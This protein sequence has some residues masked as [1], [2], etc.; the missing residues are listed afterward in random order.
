MTL[1]TPVRACKDC[2]AWL[3]ALLPL[4]LAAGLSIPLLGDNAFVG[5]EPKTLIAAGILASGPQ[6]LAE[7]VD[8]VADKSSE[9]ALG[10]PLLVFVWG[11]IAGWSEPAIRTLPVLAGLLAIAVV[12]RAGRDLFTSQAGLY[13]ALLLSGSAFFLIFMTHA[14]SFST[15]A[16]CAALCAWC[17]WRIALR[18]QP[19]GRMAQPGLLLGATG[20]L[21]MHYFGSLLLPALCVFHLLFVP[22]NPR[23]WR[24][25]ILIGLAGLAATAQLPVFLVGFR[26]TVADVVLHTRALTPPALL[27][28]FVRYLFNGLVVL[29]SF[30]AELLAILLPL[31]LVMATWWRLR[32][33][34]PTSTVWFLGFVA[35][36]F[37]LLVIGANEILRVVTESRMRYLIAMWPPLALLAGAGLCRL[38]RSQRL[39]VHGLLALWLFAGA[40]LG[41]ATD[42]RYQPGFTDRS[43]EHLVYRFVAERIPRTDAL[44]LDHEAERIYTFRL[45]MPF[46][47]YNR[48]RDDPLKHVLRLHAVHPWLWFLFHTQD[49]A[50]MDA[51]ARGLG[52]VPCERAL[53]D[54]GFVLVLYARSPVHCPESP[55]RLAFNSDIELTG[56]EIR[57]AEDGRLH[58]YAGLRSADEGLLA[59][60]SLAVH[61][62]DVNSGARV[63]QGDVGIGPGAFVPAGSAIDVSA[64]PSGEYEVHIALYDWQTGARLPARDLET[65]QV[66][67]MHVLH[68]FRIDQDA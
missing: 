64:L 3:W 56:P 11:R 37:L 60:Y 12:A 54:W 63:A 8:A 9:Q 51:M 35:A 10:W 66:G 4:L 1:T 29:P 23:W 32:T 33:R 38:G 7:V 68:S 19:P 46:Q 50:R 14:R 59:N 24:P 22:K 26:E 17:Y 65:G 15:V 2:P 57:L 53:D 25:L 61:L 13:A 18:P 20:L 36:L 21:Y 58:L 16:F 30:V 28:L 49:S 31:A 6:T 39:L 47:V 52:R 41:L 42:Y 40:W 5:D 43:N 62:I 27:S 44:V 67:D 55:A 45:D 48:F 34:R